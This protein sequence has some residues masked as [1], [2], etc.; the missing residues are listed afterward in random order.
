METIKLNQ[1]LNYLTQKGK[2]ESTLNSYCR[3]VK[4]FFT[5][6]Y[7]QFDLSDEEN[8]IKN[9]DNDILNS[10]KMYLQLD[11]KRKPSTIN[12]KLIAVKTFFKYLVEN[13]EVIKQFPFNKVELFDSVIVEEETKEKEI[14]SVDE[15][16]EVIKATYTRAKG[17]RNFEFTSAR[18]RFLFSLLISNGCR[19]EEILSATMEDMQ[20]IEEGYVVNIGMKK[21]KNHMRKKVFIVG[22]ILKYFNDYMTER[23][24]DDKYNNTNYLIV[25]NSGKKLERTNT[26]EILD[27][28]LK[29]ANINTHF[30]NHCCRH[31]CATVLVDKGN[32]S[33]L[34]KKLLGWK[35]RGGDDRMLERY[36][37]HTINGDKTLINM[38][39]SVLE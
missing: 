5:Y 34:I 11:L 8:I 13:E 17:E 39:K 37:S 36:T 29:K 23:K 16:K 33:Q 4:E 19:I 20:E 26:N 27:K 10:F 25:S 6:C 18:D 35:Q 7:L 38:V 15:A 1:W 30:T 32:S 22:D 21:V 31:F 12:A 14:V 9:A 28:I 24:M 2:R 3:N